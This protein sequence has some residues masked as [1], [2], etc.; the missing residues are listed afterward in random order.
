MTYHHSSWHADSE[1]AKRALKTRNKATKT[2]P[3][4]T[5][6]SLDSFGENLLN[7]RNSRKSRDDDDDE[8][9]DNDP[10]EMESILGMENFGPEIGEGSGDKGQGDGPQPTIISSNL[11]FLKDL[12]GLDGMLGMGGSSGDGSGLPPGSIIR[13]SKFNSNSDEIGNDEDNSDEE[14]DEDEDQD[15][16]DFDDDEDDDDDD[17]EDIGNSRGKTILEMLADKKKDKKKKLLEARRS[18]SIRP[19]CIDAL[20]QLAKDGRI[21]SKQKRVLLTDIISCS[22]RGE[23]SL[24]EHAYKLLCVDPTDEEAAEEDFVDQCQVFAQSFLE[25]DQRFN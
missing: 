14:D 23:K 20:R 17:D 16:D 25:M 8:D 22:A 21:S 12:G 19:K 11:D 7:L 5:S 24:V 1:A 2:K 18:K 4:S 9:E 3:P 6:R 13:I 15:G 10:T